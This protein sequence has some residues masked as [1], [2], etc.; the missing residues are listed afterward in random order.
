L[1]GQVVINSGRMDTVNSSTPYRHA[2]QAT[3]GENTVE[4]YLTG[5]N[6]REG[7]WRFDFRDAAH[8][9]PGSIQVDSGQVVTQGPQEVVFRVSGTGGPPLRFRYRLER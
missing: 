4:A 5:S 2:F 1:A 3:E 9:V 8:F 7:I 6:A